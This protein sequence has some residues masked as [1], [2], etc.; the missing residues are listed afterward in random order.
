V[1][2]DPPYLRIVADLRRRIEAGEFC[3]GDP[4]PSTR[5]LTKKWGVV[6]ATAT[7]ALA[8]LRQ[9]GAVNAVPGVGTVVAAREPAPGLAPEV[10]ISGVASRRGP[11]RVRR[12]RIQEEPIT[13]ASVVNRAVEIADAEGL[14]AVSMRRVAA[15]LDAAT[16]TLYRYVPSKDD[17]IVAMIDTVFGEAPYPRT[18]PAGWRAQLELAARLQWELYRRHPWSAEAISFTRPQP[19]ENALPHTEWALAAVDGLGLDGSTMLYVAIT[20]FSYVRG[21][22]INLETETRA[23]HES[24]LTHEQY[25]ATQDAT[26]DALMATGRF[27]TFAQF[28]H[29][30]DFD[31][32]LDTL[33]EFGLQHLLNGLAVLL[34]PG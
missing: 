34:E 6:M 30:L 18:R 19:T 27:P 16:M 7:K 15:E 1:P 21:T 23:Q 33:F 2:A 9:E 5:Q 17:L 3:P 4:V 26:I 8:A 13:R 28:I 12:S 25:L 14:A 32:D 11:I 20:L 31:F 29:H 10:T 22:A 24:G